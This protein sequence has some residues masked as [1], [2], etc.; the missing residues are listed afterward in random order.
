MSDTPDLS[1]TQKQTIHHLPADTETLAGHLA[2]SESTVRDRIKSL[3]DAGVK[4]PYDE[5]SRCYTLP[6]QPKVRRVSTK[7]TGSKTREAN[8][9]VTEIEKIILRRLEKNTQLIA[10]QDPDPGNEDMVL[11]FTD[12]HIGDVVEDQTGSEI[13]NTEIAKQVVNTVTKQVL[14]LRQTMGNLADFDTLHVL[15]G[16]DMITNENIYDGQAFDIESMLVDQ[17]TTAVS[18]L[19]RQLKTFAREFETVNV[20][21]QPGNH[22]KTRA[23]GVSKQANM[24]LVTYRWID[25]RLREADVDNLNFQTSEAT[26]YRTFGLR[27]GKWTGFLTHGQD[28]LQHVDA[29]A[30]SSRDWRG[31]LNEFD[32][33]VGYRGHYHES[34]RESIQNGPMVFESP[35]PKPDDEWTSKIGEGS[36][37][38]VGKRLATVHG[39]SD[40]RPVTWECVIDD[41]E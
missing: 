41:L 31:W 17:M 14:K 16:G 36:V 34:R 18:A 21:C 3:R 9:F 5:D 24:D 29:T 40:K 7:N 6:D 13:Y 26:W 11:H 19:T 32:F 2:V 1:E 15:Y 37:D 27:G 8:D 30:A 4:V 33:D 23:S 10:P 38:G 22:G 39:V 25:D 12:L 35:S 20:I 28:S